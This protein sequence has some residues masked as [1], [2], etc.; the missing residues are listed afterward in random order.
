MSQVKYLYSSILVICTLISCQRSK[1]T[2]WPSANQVLFFQAFFGHTSNS[3]CYAFVYDCGC[4]M[5]VCHLELPPQIEFPSIHRLIFCPTHC[6]SWFLRETRLRRWDSGQTRLYHL[7]AAPLYH[8]LTGK[9]CGYH[10]S[11]CGRQSWFF[12]VGG[13]TNI[14]DM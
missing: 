4:P 3:I 12:L 6:S 9:E 7:Q 5:I 14:M 8:Q 1:Y 13:L 11:R 2:A 10:E